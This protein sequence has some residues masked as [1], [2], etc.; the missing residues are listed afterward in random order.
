MFKY[1]QQAAMLEKMATSSYAQAAK[2]QQKRPSNKPPHAPTS[3]APLQVA[4]ENCVAVIAPGQPSLQ[5]VAVALQK[6]YPSLK[7]VLPLLLDGHL[8][9]QLACS[10]NTATLVNGGLKLGNAS[11]AVHTLSNTTHTKII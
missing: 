5:A 1:L 11:C 10:A 9:V 6:Q 4:R 2:Q 3:H 8:V 7:E